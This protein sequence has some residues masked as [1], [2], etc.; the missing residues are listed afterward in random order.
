M[1]STSAATIFAWCGVLLLAAGC[2]R[3]EPPPASP[4]PVAEAATPVASPSPP[5]CRD[6]GTARSPLV[7]GLQAEILVFD[8]GAGPAPDILLN[9]RI[10]NLSSA[11]VL[12]NRTALRFAM[13]VFEVRDATGAVVPG[14]PPPVPPVDGP[15]QHLE[16]QP[17]ADYSWDGSLRDVIAVDLAPGPY[18]IRLA[19]ESVA[20]STGDWAGTLETGWVRFDLPPPGP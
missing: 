20:G 17:N 13:L 10:T 12:L 19:Y 5:S 3:K 7:S 6:L 18:E 2:P 4:L 16:L 14:G 11:P 9:G 1:S 15:E 8:C